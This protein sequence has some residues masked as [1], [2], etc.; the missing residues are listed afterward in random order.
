MINPQSLTLSEFNKMTEQSPNRKDFDQ[1]VDNYIMHIIDGLDY[2]D[3]EQMCYDL[4]QREYEKLTWDDVTEEVVD[5]Y[6]EDTLIN[7]LPD[8]QWDLSSPL[9]LSSSVHISALTL[10]TPFQTF[11]MQNYNDSAKLTQ[12]SQQIVQRYCNDQSDGDWDDIMSPDDYEEY[13]ERRQ[14]E[15]SMR[16]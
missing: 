13:L 1:L 12:T 15:K 5:L 16:S 6:G 11:K 10:S 4:L 8:A 7:L 14:Y 3:M 2:K 9:S